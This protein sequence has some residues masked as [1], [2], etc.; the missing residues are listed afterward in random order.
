MHTY[1]INS[2]ERITVIGL[3]GIL[4]IAI[5]LILKNDIDIPEWLP[6][7]SVFAFFG[8]LFLLFDKW[9]WKWPIINSTVLGTPDL[10]GK[11]KMLLRSNLDQFQAEYEGT[12]TVTQT[13]TKIFLYLDGEK[14]TG[15]SL[16]AAI[17]IHT[18]ESFTLK[19]EYLSERKPDFIKDGEF[20]H[21]GM[22]KVLF[23]KNE[24]ENNGTYYADQS[25]HSFGK[26]KLIKKA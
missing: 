23:E 8:F 13:W 15:K 17:E 20:M 11:W 26:I 18:A 5:I 12:L 2:K 9:M 16:M 6:I 1:S 21:H 10:N 19:W 4:S 3:L 22:T 24:T 14:F 25:R 7:P